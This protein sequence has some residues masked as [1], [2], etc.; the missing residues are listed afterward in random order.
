[1][2]YMCRLFRGA[3]LGPEVQCLEVLG[4]KLRDHVVV[5]PDVVQVMINITLNL[6]VV[7][8]LLSPIALADHVFPFVVI[9]F[10]KWDMTCLVFF[11]KLF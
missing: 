11:L 3:V 7:A 4:L 1:M 2:V 9:T 5:L 6:V 8:L 10:L